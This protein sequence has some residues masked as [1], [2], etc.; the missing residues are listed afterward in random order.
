MYRLI[1]EGRGEAAVEKI[2]DVSI[3]RRNLR[4][5]SLVRAYAICARS[6]DRVTKRKAYEKI[7]NI[8]RIPTF[9]FMFIKFCEAEGGEEG[10]TFFVNFLF[11]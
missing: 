5:H 3:K 11:Y 8:C 6:N 1:S 7:S 10:I 9:L 2:F 4:Q